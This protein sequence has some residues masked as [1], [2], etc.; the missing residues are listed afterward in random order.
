MI[1]TVPASEPFIAS[2]LDCTPDD[3]WQYACKGMVKNGGNRGVTSFD[4]RPVSIVEKKRT[5]T[6][7]DKILIDTDVLPSVE[8]VGKTMRFHAPNMMRCRPE[9]QEK[10][11]TVACTTMQ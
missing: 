6:M 1:N 2:M 8:I 11:A 7:I 9:M 3:K 4:S 10:V 5:H